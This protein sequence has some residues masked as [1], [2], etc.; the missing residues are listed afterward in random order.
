MKSSIG[1]QHFAENLLF[2]VWLLNHFDFI[3][4]FEYSSLFRILYYYE[5]SF[6]RYY[7]YDPVD[8]SSL[9][10]VASVRLW[11]AGSFGAL[12]HRRLCN[13]KKERKKVFLN[14]TIPLCVVVVCERKSS[15]PRLKIQQGTATGVM[16]LL[17]G[18]KILF[19]A[20]HSLSLSLSL[21]FFLS[22][23]DVVSFRSY[24]RPKRILFGWEHHVHQCLVNHAII[25]LVIYFFCNFF[26]VV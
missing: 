25:T 10:H 15:R 1:K 13:K 3:L 2:L 20:S 8:I 19:A 24:H 14:Y 23:W 12:S 6:F 17:V 16:F 22:R 21:S 4:N 9:R 11:L 18:P 26:C 5:G 7:I